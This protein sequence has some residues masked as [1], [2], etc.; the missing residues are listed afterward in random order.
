[1]SINAENVRVENL[2]IENTFDF[3]KNDEKEKKDPSKI[4]N[5]QAVAV[6]L[7]T[8]S[9]KVS[10]DGVRLFAYQDTLFVNGRRMYF[11]GGSISGNIDFIFG[12]GQALFENT[13]II[14]R[15]R[16]AP[17]QSDLP[18]A[19]ITAPST[20]IDSPY[21]LV[22][23]RCELIAETGVE[24]GSVALGRPW[25]PTTQFSDGRY[26]DPN[27]IGYAVFLNTY[28]GKHIAEQG[29]TSMHGTS[30][31]G[32]KTARFYPKDSRFF[33]RGTRGPGA[34]G[35]AEYAERRKFSVGMSDEEIKLKVL[36]GWQP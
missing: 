10:F 24:D 25:H 4:R 19:Y 30:I 29:W 9:D 36:N 28:M 8:S 34:S 15:P 22:F 32:S 2:T 18:N 12:R 27:A 21:G 1:L 14:S 17:M 20:S 3:L 7:D 35:F 23:I 26:A 16:A 6:F 13:K 33:E 31:D 5:S 11:S